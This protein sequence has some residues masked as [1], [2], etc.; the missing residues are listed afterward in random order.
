MH[1]NNGWCNKRK[2]QGLKNITECEFITDTAAVADDTDLDC[3]QNKQFGK[4]EML[5]IIQKQILAIHKS[6][7]CSDKFTALKTTMVSLEKML[8]MEEEI[9]GIAFDS[10][11]DRDIYESSK[12]ISQIWS[13]EG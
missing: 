12:K 7:D 4:R 2:I 8:Q 13:Q 1:N 5:F 11:I 3:L 6:D 10:M 9:N